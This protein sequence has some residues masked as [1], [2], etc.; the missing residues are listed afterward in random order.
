MT[1]IPSEDLEGS[2]RTYIFDRDKGKF[3]SVRS[4][5]ENQMRRFG[6]AQYRSFGRG[7]NRRMININPRGAATSYSVAESNRRGELVPAGRAAGREGLAERRQQERQPVQRPKS[8]ER[9]LPLFAAGDAEGEG[10]LFIFDTDEGK[11]VGT[12]VATAAQ[13]KRF[14][15]SQ[16]FSVGSGA[17]RVMTTFNPRGEPTSYAVSETTRRGELVPAPRSA[18]RADSVA[19][20]NDRAELEASRAARLERNAQLLNIDYNNQTD[21]L[22]MTDVARRLIVSDPTILEGQTVTVD[23][24]AVLDYAMYGTPRSPG[25][26]MGGTSNYFIF[27]EAANRYLNTTFA[28][29]Q[30]MA[31]YGSTMYYRTSRGQMLTIEENKPGP[32]VDTEVEDEPRRV[33]SVMDIEGFPVDAMIG[34]IADVSIVG[35][36]LEENA[37]KLSSDELDVVKRFVR[38]Q[39][40]LEFES[41]TGPADSV[42]PTP[43]RLEPREAGVES[44]WAEAARNVNEVESQTKERRLREEQERR[45]QEREGPAVLLFEQQKQAQIESQREQQRLERFAVLAE[46]LKPQA[47]W[48]EFQYTAVPLGFSEEEF[49]GSSNQDR[50]LARW[51]EAKQDLENAKLNNSE[52][53]PA[54]MAE[55]ETLYADYVASAQQGPTFTFRDGARVPY[56]A[57]DRLDAELAAEYEQRALGRSSEQ[58]NAA[59]TNRVR[60]MQI[61]ELRNEGKDFQPKDLL[62]HGQAMSLLRSVALDSPDRILKLKSE[63]AFVGFADD[64]N[65]TSDTSMDGATISGFIDLVAEANNVGMKPMDYLTMKINDPSVIARSNERAKNR[66]GGGGG[67]TIRVPAVDDVASVFQDVARKRIGMQLG[68]DQVSQMAQSYVQQYESQLRSQMGRDV[69][70]EP[71]SA[72]TFAE[73]QIN[74]QFGMDENIYQTGLQLDVLID[75]I[76]GSR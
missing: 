26:F 63:L 28:S 24:E 8:P 61:N 27:D 73:Q 50:A 36:W 69:V 12:D 31:D 40:N 11:F 43:M 56:S 13:M 46:R 66:R 1:M 55:V 16:Y 64:R 3:V 76:G 4:A 54:L 74:Q 68:Q 33:Q 20:R 42:M 29:D 47:R 5:T 22:Q 25:L 2:G 39:A 23:L 34:D 52:A 72:D 38:D 10:R 41:R 21:W 48:R 67:F 75:M 19:L 62:S 14:G 9:G 65:Y 57:R 49:R 18:G 35:P 32:K 17:N 70:S 44:P 37:S 6:E 7:N 53:I 71:V 45:R 58:V 51:E 60:N 30:Q 59:F 15:Q